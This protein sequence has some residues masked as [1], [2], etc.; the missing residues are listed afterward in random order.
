MR[1]L[2]ATTQSQLAQDVQENTDVTEYVNDIYN[3]GIRNA[4][5]V[6]Y[7]ADVEN[8]SGSGGVKTILSYAKNFGNLGDLTMN[9]IHITTVCYAYT[10]GTAGSV[11]QIPT[12]KV[13]LREGSMHIRCFRSRL[14]IL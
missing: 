7:L 14:D 3:R 5:A 13:I 4:A 6:V 2:L 11:S 12:E 10:N 8:Q 1:T 9:E